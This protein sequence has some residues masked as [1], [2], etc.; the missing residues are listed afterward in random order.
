[1]TDSLYVTDGSSAEATPDSVIEFARSLRPRLRDLQ[2]VHEELGGYTEEIHNAFLEGGLYR[3]LQPK[4]FGGL[5]FD[6]ETFMRVGIEISRGDPGVGWAYILGSGHAFHVGSFYGEQAQ[7]ELFASDFIAPSR[8]VPHGRGSKVA[9]GYQLT[10]VWDYCSGSMWSTHALVVAPTFDGEK[11][12]GLKM[13]A[14]PRS[15]YTI[16]DD[17][18][19]G[20]TIGMQASSSNSIEVKDVFVPEHLVIDYAFREHVLGETGPVGFQLNKAPIYVGRTMTFFNAELVAAQVGAAWAALDEYEELMRTKSASFPPRVPRLDTPEYH[21]WFGKI[22]VLTDS[23]ESLLISAVNQYTAL[24]Q[25]WMDTGEEFTPDQDARLRGIVQQAARLANEAV[26]LAFTT[27]GTTS[28][29]RGSKMQKYYRDV[30]MYETHIAAQWDVT[31]SSESR[32]YFGQELT[33]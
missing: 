6:F 29:K 30:S 26:H 1:M 32:F 28:A 12:I 3:V 7:A 23:S 4:R 15:D 25:H 14:M 33:F 8:T 21:R 16:L 24:G 10:G 18:G 9:G 20:E 31:Y 2:S 5:G 17:W 27:A 11:M 22:R 19:N 13:F